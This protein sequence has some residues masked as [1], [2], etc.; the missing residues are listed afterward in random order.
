MKPLTLLV[1]GPG[2]AGG[3]LALAS[4]QAGHRVVAVVTGPSASVPIGLSDRV[5]ART[6]VGAFEVDL[7]I[8][9]VRDG[10]IAP[11]AQRLALLQ[12]RTTSTIHLSGFTSV[13]ALD[14]ATGS[15]GDVGSFHPLQTLPDPE[16][17]AASLAGSH[18][19]LTTQ[20]NRLAGVLTEF[21]ESLGMRPF[22]VGDAV[23]PA[24]HAAAACAANL[25]V[26]ALAMAEE[27][28]TSAGVDLAVALPL[29][30]TV[31]GNVFR[32]GAADALTGPV[33]RGDRATV[34]GHLHAADTVSASSG[35]Q[36]RLLMA[37][38]AL[39]ADD[40]DFADEILEF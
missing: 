6:E 3:S 23:K 30:N 11:V 17:G 8:L 37:A 32:M 38:L 16:T 40:P 13:D 7:T 26:E 20:S 18:V 12:P 27:L 24:Y 5:I 35:H 10:D 25:V 19:G 22:P 14:V 21:A 2:R 31:V 28:F 34:R 9:A 29:T 33:A 36:M 4:E 39:R 1:V 15:L